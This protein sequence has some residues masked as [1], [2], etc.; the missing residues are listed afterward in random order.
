MSVF[1]NRTEFSTKNY[2]NNTYF[3]TR[4]VA[5]REKLNINNLYNDGFDTT[6]NNTDERVA[7][8]GCQRYQ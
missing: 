4:R 3:V 2:E 6:N 1:T 8:F 5:H 7:H